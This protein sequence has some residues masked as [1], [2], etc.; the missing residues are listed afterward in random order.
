MCPLDLV[1]HSSSE[2]KGWICQMKWEAYRKIYILILYQGKGQAS[3][4]LNQILTFLD[5]ST[6]TEVY[7]WGRWDSMIYLSFFSTDH[8]YEN[9]RV[10][11]HWIPKMRI[12]LLWHNHTEVRVFSRPFPSRRGARRTDDQKQ[13]ARWPAEESQPTLTLFQIPVPAL[14]LSEKQI[15]PKELQR[16]LPVCENTNQFLF[17]SSFALFLPFTPLLRKTGS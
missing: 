4:F 5:I 1:F 11:K 10:T 9:T 3:A 16:G 2:G 8:V 12:C 7:S 6:G 14:W 17:L 15:F 13:M